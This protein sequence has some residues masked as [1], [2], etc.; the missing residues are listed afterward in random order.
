VSQDNDLSSQEGKVAMRQVVTTLIV[1]TC[2]FI[3]K[4][5]RVQAQV[6]KAASVGFN[7]KSEVNVYVIGYT[8]VNGSKRSGPTLHLKKGFKAFESNVPVGGIRYY[9]IHDANQPGNILCRQQIAITGDASFD[10]VPSPNNPKMLMIVPAKTS[11]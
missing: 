3:V 8:I 10:I 4:A 5:E 6:P 2:I 11:P 9:T 1:I 7:N